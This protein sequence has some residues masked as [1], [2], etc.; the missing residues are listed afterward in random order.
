MP[1]LVYYYRKAPGGAA[2]F[3]VPIG[4]TNRSQQYVHIPSH[5]MHCGGTWNLIQVCLQQKLAIE[6]LPHQLF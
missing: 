3:S 1:T 6:I 5:H 2:T 4:Q